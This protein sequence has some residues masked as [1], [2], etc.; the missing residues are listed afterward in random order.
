[1]PGSC[2][3]SIG[4]VMKGEPHQP[5]G[6][7]LEILNA[8]HKGVFYKARDITRL[9]SFDQARKASDYLQRLEQ[10]GFVASWRGKQKRG[11]DKL[12]VKV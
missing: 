11:A 9:C 2:T 8:M 3:N 6:V 7:A 1:M 10:R 5:K 4:E 12:Y